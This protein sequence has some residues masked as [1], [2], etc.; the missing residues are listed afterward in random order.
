MKQYILFLSLILLLGIESSG[1][2]YYFRQYTGTEG[3]HHAFIYSISQDAE[4][5]L[6]IG[7]AEGLYRFNGF[8]FEFITKEG[9]IADDFVTKIFRDRNAKIWVGHQNGSLS[10]LTKKGIVLLNEDPE[11]HGSVTDI[12]QD[13]Q[14]TIWATVQN[15]GLLTINENLDIKPVHFSIEQAPLTQ[16]I[17]AGHNKFII[18]TQENLYVARYNSIDGTMDVM[19]KIEEYPGSKV[20]EI[21]ASVPDRF[22]IVTQEDG[23]YGLR[24]D[25]S[26][27]YTFKIYDDN[28]DGWLVNLQGGIVDH[29]GTLWINSL[30]NGLIQFKKDASQNY[31][32]AGIVSTKNGLVS[33]NVKSMFE[34]YEGNLWLGMY[35]DG[36]LRYIDNN[37][38]FYNF[39]IENELTGANAIAGNSERL[40]FS[41]GN[42]LLEMDLTSDTILT[43]YQLPVRNPEDRLNT[44]YLA[45]DGSIWLGYDRSG[46]YMSGKYDSRFRAVS[47]SKDNLS[48]SIN[49]IT[50]RNGFIWISTKKGICKIEGK[51]GKMRWFNKDHGLPHNNIRQLYI[52]SKERVLIATLCGEIYY[53][54][55]ENE[56]SILDGSWIGP[57]NSVISIA[58]GRDGILWVATQ[59]N[60]VWKIVEGE[61][62][63]YTRISGLLTDYCY[64]LKLTNE[65]EPVITHRGGISQIDPETDR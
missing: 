16:I 63:D 25:S 5:Y 26:E 40:L 19:E 21:I 54:N 41:I 13:D 64:S 24:A 28:S 31:S 32:R 3:L 48:R 23:L 52:D 36:L 53:I 14:G 49:H 6:W 50:G 38:K 2:Q 44:I 34:D 59:G 58:E 45:D 39:S 55:K 11:N 42:R 65:G 51:T 17:S 29:T 46:L 30:G 18:G 60:G 9:G 1:Q 10:V 61:N 4:G 8:E 56:I 35:G 43:A 7:T 15:Q 20:V 47:I 22:V 62:Q 57:S 33:G 27:N 12:I 37:L